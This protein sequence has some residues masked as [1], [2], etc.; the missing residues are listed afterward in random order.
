M[1]MEVVRHLS[2]HPV[3]R[4]SIN[5]E[6]LFTNLSETSQGVSYHVI[7][8]LGPVTV[9]NDHRYP[10]G[11]TVRHPAHVVFDVPVGEA[12]RPAQLTRRIGLRCGT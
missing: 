7:G 8:R 4:E 3:D 11:F 10:T 6:T 1:G 12:I 5:A 9:G 2:H